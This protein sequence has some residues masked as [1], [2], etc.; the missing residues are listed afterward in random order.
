M[1]GK[2]LSRDA[3]TAAPGAAAAAMAWRFK[4][5]LRVTVVAKATFGFANEGA[6]PRLSPAPI[7]WDEVHH[8]NHPARSIRLATD[9]VPRMERADVLFTGQAFAPPGTSVQR[10]PVRLGLFDGNRPLLQKALIVQQ[11]GGVQGVPIVYERAFGGI[12]WFDNPFGVG[13]NEGSGEPSILDP[14]EPKRTAG[15]GPIAR[16]WPRRRRLL[17]AMPAGAL[18]ADIVELPDGFAW[19]Y[20]QSAPADQQIGFLKGDEWIVLE[21]LHPAHPRIRM[22]LPGARAAARIFG[23]TAFGRR[24]G[25][26][27][28]LTLDLLHIHGDEQCVTA[29]WRNSFVLPSDEALPAVRVVAGVETP[30]EPIEWPSAESLP[31]EPATQI[32]FH[33][34]AK[35]RSE[36]AHS[37]TIVLSDGD[38]E[39]IDMESIDVESIDVEPAREPTIRVTR[40]AD[41]GDDDETLQRSAGSF[42]ATPISDLVLPAKAALPF[43]RDVGSFAATPISTGA[44]PAKAA[45][46]FVPSARPSPLAKAESQGVR[47]RPRAADDIHGTVSLAPEEMDRA[48]AKT[49]TPFAKRPAPPAPTPPRPAAIPRPASSAPDAAAP[50]VPAARPSAPSVPAPPPP[51]PAPVAAPSLPVAAPSPPVAAPSPPVAA[52]SL[53]VAAPSEAKPVPPP[54]AKPPFKSGS[55]WATPTDVAP[56]PSAAARSSS[57]AAKPAPGTAGPPAPTPAL[58]RG[59]YDRFG[60]P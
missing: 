57:R 54:A 35:A 42:A 29:T 18:R 23:L 58:K 20:F 16:A 34:P 41:L 1:A 27:I 56:A 6:M 39:S 12:G 53:P 25:E 2:A 32:G 55:P 60:K 59:L 52:P 17:E 38:V 11:K 40:M 43:Q 31:G 8:G 45:L 47:P 10:L 49:A 44:P 4:G 30:G 5:E 26:Q 48:A 19:D 24:D 22:C 15:F 28:E 7:V 46:P 36:A 14:A 50:P 51:V 3:V 33:P 37:S 9:V 13:M 21:S